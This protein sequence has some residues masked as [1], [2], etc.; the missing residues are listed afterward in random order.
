MNAS[1]IR[2]DNAFEAGMKVVIIYDD[3][4]GAVEAK[5]MFERAAHRADEGLTWS[6]KRWRLDMLAR[7]LTA[8]WALADADES[9][10]VVLCLH[11][12]LSL[13]DWV[14]DWLEK[15]AA[16]RQVQ[17]A[18]LA[19]WVG[20]NGGRLAATAAPDLRRF[21]GRH[22]LCFISGGADPGEDES[23]D[24]PSSWPR[25]REAVA[26]PALRPIQRAGRRARP[27]SRA[28]TIETCAEAQVA[29]HLNQC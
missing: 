19:V 27:F 11:Q 13:D 4:A 17:E 18:A 8:A 20:G 15:W 3:F 24:F 16:R 1:A 26:I 28:S 9:H 2:E 10:L 29:V 22:G 21:A 25:G 6:V 14:S 5:A 23:A 12:P 7:P